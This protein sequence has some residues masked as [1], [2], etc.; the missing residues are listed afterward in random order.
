MKTGS[1]DTGNMVL[2]GPG[3]KGCSLVTLEHAELVEIR[4]EPGASIETHT[5]PMNVIFYVKQGAC[6][7]TV[8]DSSSVFSAGT[9][10]VSPAEIPKSM[11]HIEGN[12]AEV[13]VIKLTGKK[14]GE[15]SPRC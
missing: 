1:F 8:G 2:I 6:R 15:I 5:M 10:V 7:I 11:E 14:N 12:P 3:L 4:L 9:A 13:L